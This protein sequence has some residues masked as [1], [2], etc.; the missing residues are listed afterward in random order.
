MGLFMGL[1]AK[2]QR[3]LLFELI[4]LIVAGLVGFYIAGQFDLMEKFDVLFHRHEDDWEFDE[5]FVVALFQVFTLLGLSIRRWLK[6]SEINDALELSNQQLL[7]ALA[8]VQQLKGIIPICAACKKIRDDKG[9]WHQVEAYVEQ[10]STAQFSHGICPDC[11]DELYPSVAEEL[12]KQTRR[13]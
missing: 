9:Y 6:L 1:S 12:R 2:L 10:H 4:I 7:S 8:E 11:R 3:L 5:I 13:T